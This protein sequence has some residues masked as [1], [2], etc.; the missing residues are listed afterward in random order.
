MDAPTLIRVG[1]MWQVT[2]ANNAMKEHTQ[3]WQALIYYHQAMECYQRD[4]DNLSA[5]QL[6]QDSILD[7][8]STSPTIPN[9]PSGD[10]K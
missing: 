2:Y 3:A 7:A 4:V 8:A 6:S 1:Y 10:C 9:A 5:L